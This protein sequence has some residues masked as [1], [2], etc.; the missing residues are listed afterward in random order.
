MIKILVSDKLS[1]KGVEVLRESGFHVDVKTGLSTEEQMTIISEYDGI[2]IRSAT[3]ITREMLSS[4]EKLKVI[5][6]AGSGLDNVDIPEATKRGIVVMNTPGGN[7]ITTAEHTISMMLSLARHIP[8]ATKS[9]KDGKWEKSRFMGT[10]ICNHTLGIIGIGN[11]GTIV[12]DRAKALGMQIIAHDPFISAEKAKKTGLELVSLDEMYSR[13]DFI[14][15]HTPVTKETRNIINSESISKMKDGVFIINCARGGIVNEQDLA[16]AIKNGK[17]AGAA[18]DVY[19]KEPPED[20]TLIE[21]DQVVCTPH[22]GAS[23][24]EAQEKVAVAVARQIVDYFKKNA[25]R[26]AVNVPSVAPEDI[27]NLAP[28]LK[29]AEALGKFQANIISGGLKEVYLEYSG[30][31]T[32]Y[33]TQL[34]SI[35]FLK[36]ILD[37]V[38]DE[39]INFVN[40]SHIA[41]ERG[42]KVIESMAS[43]P[44][45]FTQLIKIQTKTDETESIIE[46]TIFG[47]SDPR[48][49]K[50]NQFELECIPEGNILVVQNYDKPG[51]I[52]RI[53]KMLGD[54]SVNIAQMQ[55]GR[56]SKSSKALM[57]ITIDSPVSSELAEEIK[58]IPNIIEFYQLEI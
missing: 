47:L 15:V 23:T 32:N 8:Q 41:R 9:M 16:Q 24:I 38:L 40:A 3:K 6:R 20:T 22:L 1:P 57:V 46:G 4:A 13:A 35:A 34:V 53:G 44:E 39:G 12:A 11:I 51:V 19:E 17:V 30:D 50:I 14:T 31:I 21:L 5:G 10:E 25:I 33:D 54:H 42:I 49:V 37:P 18:L 56:D 28:F 45:N 55:V 29:L 26:N 52:G 7:T 2:V 43:E 58:N 48:I 36:G 27:K